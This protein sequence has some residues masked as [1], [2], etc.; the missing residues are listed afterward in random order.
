MP[1]APLP[2]CLEPRCPGRAVHRGRCAR[3]RKSEAER[4]YGRDH[5]VDRVVNRPGATCERCGT[6]DRLQRDHRI[7]PSLGG[8]ESQA[9]KRWLCRPCH[10]AVGVKS[11]ARHAYGG[12]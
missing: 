11:S 6:S 12:A 10:D 2:A 9:N 8:D 1:T 7:P 5:R 4:G 3:H